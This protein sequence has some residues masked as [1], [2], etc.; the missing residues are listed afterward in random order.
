[1]EPD[2]RQTAALIANLDRHD[3]QAIRAAVDSLIQQAADSPRLRDTLHRRLTEA[4][5][6]DYWPLAYILGNLPKP[7][8]A[9]IAGLLEALNHGD[10]DIRWAIALLLVRIAKENQD[11]EVINSL[12]QLCATGSDNQKRMALYVLRDLSLSDVA[13]LAA[14]LGALHDPDPTVRVAAAISLKPRRDIGDAGKNLLLGLYLN[15]V[16][17]KVRHAVAITLAALGA[18][19]EDFVRA[20]KENTGSANEQT[21]KAA[22]AA[23]ELLEKR[24]SAPIGR[25]SDR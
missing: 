12:I 20:L 16:E 21:K 14:L 19:P 23:L 5:H 8:S 4:G 10:P 25:A 22:I 13:S 1:M 18:P 15:D 2:D 9:T 11:L 7:S 24:R 6:R 3:K 17:L